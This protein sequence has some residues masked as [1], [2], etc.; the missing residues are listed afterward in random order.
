MADLRLVLARVAMAEQE[1]S[2][3]P[4]IAAWALA[5]GV[6]SPSLRYLAGH[7]GADVRECR[8]LFLAAMEELGVPMPPRDDARRAMARAWASEMIAGTLT[9]YE[10]SRLIWRKAWDADDGPGELTVFVGL[11][12]E[13]EDDR[14][15]RRGLERNM[16][17][18]ARGLLGSGSGSEGGAGLAT[19][20]GRLRWPEGEART[21]SM[22]WGRTR[23]ELPSRS[24]RYGL[25]DP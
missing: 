25:R 3:L 9:P 7:P 16:L 15:G 1:T 2:E 4:L 23:S 21:G 19:P 24:S 22:S 8:D 14:R 17:E 10:A 12:S 6:D 20:R 18:A 11:A 13:W 5:G